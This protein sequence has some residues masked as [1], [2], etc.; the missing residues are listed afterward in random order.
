M[1]H[2]IFRNES[3]LSHSP[4]AWTNMSPYLHLLSPP[5]A[6]D[7]MSAAQWLQTPTPTNQDPHFLFTHS[8]LCLA[9]TLWHE[10]NHFLVWFK[11]QKD[12]CPYKIHCIGFI[13][14]PCHNLRWINFGQARTLLWVDTT[15][16]NFKPMQCNCSAM[17]CH[18]LFC[19]PN[20]KLFNNSMAIAIG[21]DIHLYVPKYLAQN[22]TPT[23]S[24]SKDRENVYLMLKD[25]WS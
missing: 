15:N 25:L 12:L 11:Q 13:I 23:L 6:T 8:R 3:L 20:A 7:V 1:K 16:L 18:C 9:V 17:Q 10:T 21:K 19:N 22:I 14:A 2:L 4:V 5:L 24:K